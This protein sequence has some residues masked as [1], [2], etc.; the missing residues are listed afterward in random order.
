MHEVTVYPGDNRQQEFF[1]DPDHAIAIIRN[2]GDRDR[3]KNTEHKDKGWW[4][5]SN[6][7]LADGGSWFHD[8]TSEDE[9]RSLSGTLRE[10]IRKLEEQYQVKVTID[11]S[12]IWTYPRRSAKNMKLE[13]ARKQINMPCYRCSS[14]VTWHW[15]PKA[16]QS[17]ME[18]EHCGYIGFVIPH[19]EVL[20]NEVPE[21]MERA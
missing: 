1:E 19:L 11:L 13:E 12:K 7:G 4:V 9:H 14:R 2:Y 17:T 3:L 16:I 5:H 21:S 20:D 18:C 10:V 8:K 15:H 6:T